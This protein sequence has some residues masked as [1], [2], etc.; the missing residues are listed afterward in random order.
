MEGDKKQR[1]DVYKKQ[2]ADRTTED[3]KDIGFARMR[4]LRKQIEAEKDD[5]ERWNAMDCK[6][7]Y[8]EGKAVYGLLWTPKYKIHLKPCDFIFGPEWKDA[9]DVDALYAKAYERLEKHRDTGATIAL[10]VNN[11][12]KAMVAV[13][14][15]CRDLGLKLDT[16]HF[17][18]VG[19][20][21]SI[22]TIFA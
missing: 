17:N 9:T 4:I 21:Y 6:K 15:V 19:G 8:V 18:E 16:L 7:A 2:R 12:H 13:I 3:W 14:R 11:K 10:F 1:K 20:D 22:Q 5:P